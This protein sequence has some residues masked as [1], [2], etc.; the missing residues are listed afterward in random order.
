[1]VYD[2][3]NKNLLNNLRVIMG[4]ICKVLKIQFVTQ[5]GQ[6]VATHAWRAR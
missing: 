6:I 1:M 4:V 3:Y 2:K 5:K